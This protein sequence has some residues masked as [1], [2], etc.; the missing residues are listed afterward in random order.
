MKN[1]IPV[2][3]LTIF[4]VL[5]SSFA[6]AY[7]FTRSEARDAVQ[8]S[9]GPVAMEILNYNMRTRSPYPPSESRRLSR[10]FESNLQNATSNSKLKQT[11]RVVFDRKLDRMIQVT[12]IAAQKAIYAG[13]QAVVEFFGQLETQSKS[14]DSI[15]IT[16][17]QLGCV[18]DYCTVPDGVFFRNND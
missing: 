12:N 15:T 4:T 3:A 16:S 11:L 14:G 17:S 9:V 13:P 1:F 18:G 8:K 10:I 6:H 7:D 5:T 2:A